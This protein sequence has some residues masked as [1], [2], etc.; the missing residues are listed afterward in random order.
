MT[1][2]SVIVGTVLLSSGDVLP[3][4]P[5]SMRLPVSLTTGRRDPREGV[6]W[7]PATK[8]RHGAVWRAD[9][10]AGDRRRLRDEEFGAAAAPGLRGARRRRG[11]DRLR[12]GPQH[13][14]LARE[15]PAGH[16]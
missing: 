5:R 10:P 2:V 9:P 1:F 4:R 11:G 12:V 3:R 8:E 13:P 7:W 15:R 16:R 6:W 14:V